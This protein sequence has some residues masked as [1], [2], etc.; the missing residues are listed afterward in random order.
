M[1]E[2]DLLENTSNTITSSLTHSKLEKVRRNIHFTKREL[3][4]LQYLFVGISAKKIARILHISPKTVE[5]YTA[6]IKTKLGATSKAEI[7]YKILSLSIE[8]K[9]DFINKEIFDQ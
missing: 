2:A 8:N 4:C 3:E 6:A 5:I 1:K 9:S 7:A